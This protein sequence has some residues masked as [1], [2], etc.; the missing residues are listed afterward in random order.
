MWL[1]GLVLCIL[2]GLIPSAVY[3]WF[4]NWLDRHEKE[5]RRLLILVFL[6]GAVPA[7]ILAIVAQLILDI[8]T[9][10]ILV[11]GSLESELVGGSL[12]A[13]ITEEITKGLGVLL[14]LLLARREMDSVLDGIVYGAV[15]GLGFAFTENLLYFGASLAEEGWGS[16]AFV[17][18]LRTVPF[19]LNQAN[20]IGSA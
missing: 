1:I 14:V 16:W 11:E 9:S 19:G 13:P 12:W 15:A 4:I 18:V 3:G 2:A 7:L 5:P 8:P 17:V 20:C 6:W 10:W